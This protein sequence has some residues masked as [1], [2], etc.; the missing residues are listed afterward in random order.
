MKKNIQKTVAIEQGLAN[1]ATSANY[2][3][4]LAPVAVSTGLRTGALRHRMLEQTGAE[5]CAEDFIK[6]SM[7]LRGDP[8]IEE[9]IQNYFSDSSVVMLSLLGHEVPAEC[10]IVTL[11]AGVTL[12]ME[13][14]KA[15]NQRRSCRTYTGDPLSL[16]YLATLVRSMSGVSARG[17]VDLAQGGQATLQF[18][19]APSAGGLY[20]IDVYVAALNIEGLKRGLYRFDPLADRLIIDGDEQTVDQLLTATAFTDDQISISRASALFLLV[21]QPWRSM[22][23]Y[24]SR[25]VRF[26]FIEAGCMAENLHLATMALGFGSVDCSSFYDDEVNKAMGL[27]G[28]FRFLAHSIIVG[29]SG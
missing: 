10:Q 1:A 19:T 11:P 26:L 3:K 16:E 5:L 23:K 7:L 17:D 24:G 21:G 15:L 2:Y 6:S 28:R 18:R 25:G 4:M 8:E 22:R 14:G 9:S 13:L 27:D 20:P 29:C 12:P